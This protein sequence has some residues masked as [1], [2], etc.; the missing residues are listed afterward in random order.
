M[1]KIGLL[2]IGTL[3]GVAAFGQTIVTEAPSMTNSTNTL[4]AADFQIESRL[5]Y[6]KN[7]LGNNFQ[8]PINLF[9]VGLGKRFE[10]RTQ[11][12]LSYHTYDNSDMT[13]IR[14]QNI[15]MGAKYGIIGGSDKKFTLATIVD[16]DLPQYK[17]K[18]RSGSI[19]LTASNTIKEKHAISYSLVYS[20]ASH[21][22]EYNNHFFR[23]TLMYSTMLSDRIGIYGEIY[24]DLQDWYYD[25]ND[26][27]YFSFDVGFIYLLKDNIQ[28]DYSF[29]SGIDHYTTYHALGFNILFPKK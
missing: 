6:A 18:S 21:N 17:S 24:Y 5:E 23:A 27:S 8:L 10:F 1:N 26:N 29:G 22:F 9:R 11:N 19:V 14:F 25:P 7:G 28:L 16:I 4:A 12:G 20:L 2:L 13:S 15:S 3:V